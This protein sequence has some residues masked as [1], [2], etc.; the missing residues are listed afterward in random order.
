MSAATPRREFPFGSHQLEQFRFGTIQT[1]TFRIPRDIQV[2]GLGPAFKAVSMPQGMST[3]MFVSLA[4]GAVVAGES[5]QV[6][7]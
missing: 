7:Q 5:E 6:H 1:L 3:A 2:D 4:V